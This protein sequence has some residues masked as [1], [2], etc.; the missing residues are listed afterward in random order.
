M[1]RKA[2]I[3]FF[4]MVI[5]SACVLSYELRV[6][7]VADI[8]TGVD[9]S[10]PRRF[11]YAN[12]LLFF[13][14][15]DGIHGK[16]LWV[17]DGTSAG[18]RLVKDINPGSN[19]GNPWYMTAMDN[20]AYFRA[21]DG[22]NGVHLWRSDGTEEGTWMVKNLSDEG[23]SEPYDFLVHNGEIY[24]KTYGG[25]MSLWRS[26]GSTEGT[27][28]IANI[29]SEKGGR[30]HNED[31]TS[32]GNL[33]VFTGED[34]EHGIELWISDGTPDG[35]HMVSDIKPGI[36]SSGPD[37]LTALSNY[38][39]FRA[40]DGIHGNELWVS[41]GTSDGTFLIDIKPGV[42]S[43]WPH[44]FFEYDGHLLFGADGWVEHSSTGE[45]WKTD[46][47][48][49]GTLQIKEIWPGP[50]GSGPYGFV[51]LGGVVLFV[52]KDQ[53]YAAD[54]LGH[55]ELW[56]TDGTSDGTTILADVR[57]GYKGSRPFELTRLGNYIFFQA[58]DGIHGAELWM[59]DGSAE[60]TVLVADIVDGPDG[61]FPHYIF[62]G[63]DTLYFC[64]NDG[65]TGVE[66]WRL[67]II[68]PTRYEP[69][70]R[71]RLRVLDVVQDSSHITI[72]IQNT[73]TITCLGEWEIEAGL[74]YDTYW[75]P[76]YCTMFFKQT[77]AQVQLAP[78]SI[79]TVS[80]SLPSVSE[81][82]QQMLRSRLDDIWTKY[83]DKDPRQD[84]IGIIVRIGHEKAFTFIP[85][86]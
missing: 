43:S 22:V 25:S 21:T 58:D 14:A 59:T 68:P 23:T 51:E 65:Q 1:W 54:Y 26:D 2:F 19:A 5:I 72:T 70:E 60:G 6:E 44:Y 8:N 33:V 80:F 37:S 36:S 20:V 18:T 10:N 13:E 38:V 67:V 74:S 48:A 27:V 64:A 79:T 17:S 77:G 34:Y 83:V 76:E 40:N 52:V 9:P 7:L 39:F 47:T 42:G 86:E 29:W 15:D 61:S 62:V 78:G 53:L 50:C 75:V 55:G 81:D 28:K 57:E 84:Y 35:T 31:L 49:A 4:C 85:L 56:T 69:P 82:T 24:F 71:V 3:F 30:T 16:E 11:A 63:G 45:L 66:L 12:G 41:D 73:G 46:G 32:L